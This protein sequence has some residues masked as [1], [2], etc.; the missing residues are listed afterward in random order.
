MDETFNNIEDILGS[1]SI[2]NSSSSSSDEIRSDEIQQPK[3]KPD[4]PKVGI[5]DDK[6]CQLHIQEEDHQ[7]SPDRIIAIRKKLKITG[8]YDQLIPIE[9]VDPTKE[10]L[11]LV[12]TNKYV[13]KVVRV[14]SNYKRAMI[15]CGDVKVNGENSL[16]SAGIAVGG[17]LAAVNTV[18]NTNI[19]K[20]FCNVRPPGHHA[21]SHEASGFCIF[22]NVAIGVKKALTYPSIKRVLIFDWDLHHGNGTERIFKC[23]KNVMFSSFHRAKP[24]YPNSG[25]RDYIG[26][27]GNI[28]NYPFYENCTVEE[29]MGDFN[30]FLIKAN[31]FQ[32]DIIFISCGFDS[33]KDDHYHAL[34]LTLNEFKVMT[35]ELCLLANKYCNGRLISVLEGGYTPS[36][37][38]DCAAVH[39]NELLNN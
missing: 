3:E 9:P 33:H 32:P 15:D 24:F 22:N 26:K 39:V 18:I 11:M 27:Y 20:V 29:Y 1:P 17:V 6:R 13:N 37:V 35:K 10:D 5:V 19:K 23:N 2:N 25:S 16:V 14:C 4:Q 36:V 8:L 21:S 12:H 34:P 7:E 38:A 30:D 28:H 31:A